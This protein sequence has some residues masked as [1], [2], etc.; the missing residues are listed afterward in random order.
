MKTA[1]TLFA[2]AILFIASVN[3]FSQISEVINY[4]GRLTDSEGVPV[5]NNSYYVT[6]SLYDNEWAE[7]SIW[8]EEIEVAT[9]DGFFNVNLGEINSFDSLGL[10]FDMTYFLGI[11]LASGTEFFPRT[12]LAVTPYSFTAKKL[13]FPYMDTVETTSGIKLTMREKGPTLVIDKSFGRAIEISNSEENSG[14]PVVSV[15]DSGRGGAI[16]ASAD[17]FRSTAGYFTT[18]NPANRAPTFQIYNYGMGN[19]MYIANENKADTMPVIYTSNQ[20]M[21]YTFLIHSLSTFDDKPAILLN[22]MGKGGGAEF[23]VLNTSNVMSPMIANTWGLGTAGEFNSFN[24]NN[25]ATTLNAMTM[26]KN[27][28]ANFKVMSETSDTTGFYFM[29]KSIGPGAEFEIDNVLNEEATVSITTNGKGNAL[30]AMTDGIGSAARFESNSETYSPT[31]YAVS[32]SDYPAIFG[33]NTAD[34]PAASF[35]IDTMN[36]TDGPVVLIDHQGGGNAL[37]LHST[38]NP[39]E[40]ALSIKKEGLDGVAAIFDGHVKIN[41]ELQKMSGSF[42]IDHPLDPENK[43]LAHSFVESPDMKNIYDGVVTLD[44]NGEAEITLPEWFEALNEDFRYQLTCIGGWAQVYISQ[45]VQDNK[46]RISGGK[47]GMKV[48]W[49]ITGIRHDPWAEQKRITV[50][51]DKPTGKKGKY[52]YPEYY[53]NK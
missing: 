21:G 33:T 53:E 30:F 3:L 16:K 1:S 37:R 11:R 2:I 39:L 49:M 4:Q 10:K 32:N 12:K 8:S 6:F 41:G 18:S 34:G 20:S 45:E 35:I 24:T 47:A 15:N 14:F 38:A 48:S 44:K 5:E 42:V 27:P 28:V 7:E 25:K 23:R 31:V 19:A 22:A 50:E 52:L 29:T 51:R 13:E 26:G 43:L 46:F 36:R 9:H 17:G 40:P